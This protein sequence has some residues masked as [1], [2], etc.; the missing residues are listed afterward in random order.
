MSEVSLET[1]NRGPGLLKR[2][3]AGIL[4]VGKKIAAKIGDMDDDDWGKLVIGAGIYAV[5]TVIGSCTFHEMNV[6]NAIETATYRNMDVFNQVAALEPLN[7]AGRGKS[8][9]EVR[10]EDITYGIRSG[11][12]GWNWFVIG[13]SHGGDELLNIVDRANIA[14]IPHQEAGKPAVMTVDNGHGC[15][16]V[17][18]F[19]TDG[20]IKQ[21]ARALL[22]AFGERGTPGIYTV[23]VMPGGDVAFSPFEQGRDASAVCPAARPKPVPVIVKQKPPSE[24]PSESAPAPVP[25]PTAP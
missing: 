7:V 19:N 14:L 3:G 8:R 18:H 12:H 9:W 23:P 6:D 24:A 22:K 16:Q 17:N 10:Q 5:A 25:V 15:L 13:S 1:E 21:D 4:S 2:A 11:D 20:Q